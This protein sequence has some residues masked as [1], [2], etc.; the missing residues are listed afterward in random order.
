M[1]I[2]DVRINKVK[3]SDISLKAFANITIDDEF[4]VKGL[5]IVEGKNG[6][7]VAFPSTQG[8][9]GEWYDDAYPITAE[10]REYVT[11]TV[12]D[13]YMDTNKPAITSKA[14]RNTKR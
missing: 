7:F 1:K 8:D 6:T 13:A 11:D 10:C 12:L 2:T 9:D 3:K 14:K 4:V 5:K